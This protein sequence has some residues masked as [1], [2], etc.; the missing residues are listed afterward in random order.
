MDEVFRDFDR[1]TWG[2]GL[3]SE[4]WPPV[5]LR[6]TGQQLVLSADVPGMGEDEIMVEATGQSITI[7]GER[8]VEPPQGY[9]AHRKERSA[10]RFNR[11]FSLPCQI[12]LEMVQASVR[13]GVLTVTA[14]KLPEARPKQIAI[15]AK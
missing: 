8:K 9:T 10:I 13:N 11:S 5:D 2:L 7:R 15:Q 1:P 3:G 4:A 12:D 14:T 6:D